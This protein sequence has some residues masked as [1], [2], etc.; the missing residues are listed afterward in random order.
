MWLSRQWAICVGSLKY[1]RL[2]QPYIDTYSNVRKKIGDTCL[3]S[4]GARPTNDISI[5]LEIR[6]NFAVP[7]FKM[8]STDPNEIVHTSRQLH[9]RDVCKISLG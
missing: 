2:L 1:E 7:W 4:P 5:E 3:A 9:C 8:C 6:P